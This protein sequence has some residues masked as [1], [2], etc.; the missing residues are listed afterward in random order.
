MLKALQLIFE[1]SATWLS[2]A[3]AKRSV[4]Q[5]MLMYLIPTMLIAGALEAWGLKTLGNEPSTTAFVERT[6]QPVALETIIRYEISQ[7]V[8]MLA[9]L[10]LL[11]LLLNALMRSLHCKA[12]YTVVFTTIAYSLGPVFLMMAVDGV[13]YVNSWICRGI[14][15]LLAAKVFYVGLVRVIKP[16]PTN[17]LGIYL[18][19]SFLIFA[20]VGLA[21]FVALQVLENGLLREIGN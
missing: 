10:F 20:F 15:A 7:A 19:G 1:P 13:P 9:V 2:I 12:T 6:A 14:G 18:T 3:Q 11:P 17:A 8:L 21:H 4:W 16:E 5:V